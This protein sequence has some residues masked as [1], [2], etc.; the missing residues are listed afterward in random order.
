VYVEDS[1]ADNYF[2]GD[3]GIGHA[4]PSNRLEVRESVS[5][6][7]APSNHVV[8]IFNTSS[9][10]SGDVLALRI[11]EAANAIGGG[12]NF[13]SFQDAEALSSLGA[14]QGNGSG[15][16]VL[17]GPGNDYAE[18]L[19]QFN[20]SERIHPGDVVGVYGG[21]V[22]KQTENAD[23]VMV[24]STGAIVSGN[25]PGEESRDG[26][27]LVAFIGQVEVRVRGPVSAGD[28]ILPSGLNDGTA[29]A[30]APEVL[31]FEQLGQIIGQAWEDNSDLGIKQI[32]TLVGL[33]QPAAFTSALQSIDARLDA[34]EEATGMIPAD[35]ISS[36]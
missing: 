34:L 28:V 25:D 19:P 7:A 32:R 35:E 16:V 17:A 23:L 36:Q 10:G 11:N 1:G 26:Y 21:M 15:G 22:T 24:A 31:N 12:N 8:Q 9:A 30:V 20:P 2:A 6:S 5:G 3:T 18:Y 27:S 29:I 4:T 14:I 33:V 13:I